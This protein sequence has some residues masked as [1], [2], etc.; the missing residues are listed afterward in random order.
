VQLTERAETNGNEQKQTGTSRHY[1]SNNVFKHDISGQHVN[2]EGPSS[3][4]IALAG[5]YRKLYKGAHLMLDFWFR[6]GVI[7]NAA[8]SYCS[9]TLSKQS[10]VCFKM[11][12]QHLSFFTLLIVSYSSC[13]HKNA[14]MRTS[15]SG[16]NAATHFSLAWGRDGRN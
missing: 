7:A 3:R 13:L 9:G 14:L 15:V 5:S 11:N 2:I 16:D 4:N 10:E 1:F 6:H 12:A 8:R